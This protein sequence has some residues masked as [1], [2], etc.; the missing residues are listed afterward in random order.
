MSI[1]SM[2]GFARAEGAVGEFGW[3]WELKSVN[4][5]N[6]DVRCRFPSG[7]ENLDGFVR[8]RTA[9]T[10]KRGNLAV[11]LTI[12]D[13]ASQ[14]RLTINRVALEQILGVIAEFDGKISAEPPRI[15]GLLAL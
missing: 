9:E 14:G 7:Y 6:L 11:T 4:G 1:A 2:T 3:T 15:D 8:T 12:D 5:R 13:A 10:V